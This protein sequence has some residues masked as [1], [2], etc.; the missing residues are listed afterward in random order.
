[1]GTLSRR[2]GMLLMTLAAVGLVA[3]G[4]SATSST[5]DSTTTTAAIDDTGDTVPGDVVLASP[6]ASTAA[7]SASISRGLKQEGTEFTPRGDKPGDPQGE[8]FEA[9]KE[10]LQELISGD[11]DCSFTLA[12]EMVDE[13]G[14]YGPSVDY[15]NHPAG[16]P[17]TGQLP[18]GDVGIWD[19]LEGDEACAAAQMNALV[20]KVASKVDNMI[21]IFGAMACAGKK[22]GIDLPAVD[23]EVDLT[24][25]MSSNVTVTGLTISDAKIK[26]LADSGTNPVFLSTITITMAIPN[27]STFTGQ[28]ILKHIPT[29]DDNSTY[30]GKLSVKMTKSDSAFG[31][32]CTTQDIGTAA[33]AGVMGGVVKYEKSSA[34]SLVY[35]ADYAEFCGADADPFDDDN[36]LNRENAD[37]TN[38]TGWGSNYNYGLFSLNPVNGTGAVAYAWQAGSGDQ[39]TRVLNVTT[40]VAADDSASGTAFYGFGPGVDADATLG[41]IDGFVCNWARGA[42]NQNPR[43]A[44][45]LDTAGLGFDLAQK[46]VLS[47][48]AA[49]DI[50]TSTDDNITFAPSNNC[51]LAAGSPF[52]YQNADPTAD[53]QNDRES[54]DVANAVDNDLVPLTDVTA[55]FTRPTA[56]V[57]VGGSS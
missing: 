27:G 26:R 56:P 37:S 21:S 15:A 49:A 12:M 43:D 44:A 42:I 29:A 6:T 57:D 19:P 31:G 33:T 38:P 36:N 18:Q 11:G 47:R 9:R 14:C 32:G 1:M 7:A 17:T 24:S 25:A 45:S 30:K 23:A 34:T 2:L 39:R 40:T 46:Q 53:S 13:P 28:I 50:F 22:A 10:A 51:D 54:G 35:E 41:S 52:T 4:S 20:K 16:S 8:H 55:G 48:A 5:T 3:C